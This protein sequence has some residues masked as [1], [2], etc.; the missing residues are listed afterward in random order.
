[1]TG[2]ISKFTRR[3]ALALTGG[4]A[5]SAMLASMPALAATPDAQEALR[6]LAGKM[7]YSLDR[8]GR[9]K[10]K[11]AGHAPLIKVD[12]DG[13]DVLIRAATQHPMAADH[14]IVKHILLDHH[15]NFLGEQLFDQ[16]FDMP[17]SRFQLNGYT[18][19]VYVVSMCNIHDNW[20][21]VAE[22]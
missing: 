2:Q 21:S 3:Q 4:G 8:P 1:M 6:V 11:E 19:D 9:W 5:A 17:R 18:G 22:V 15:L 7:F 16:V 20:I 13:K 14:F 12:K 10:G